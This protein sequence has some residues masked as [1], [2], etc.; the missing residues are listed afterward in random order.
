MCTMRTRMGEQG[1][2]NVLLIPVIL[3]GLLFVGAA[4]FAFWAY[5]GRQDYKNNSDAKV[6]AAVQNNT[7]A[8]Q[9]KDAKQYAEASKNPLKIYNGPDSFGSVKV[10]YPKTWS[11]YVD[12]TSNSY[13][14]DAYFHQDYVPST[15]S[16]Q[17]YNLR[18]Q[19]NSQSY[20]TQLAQYQSLIQQGK[21][22]ATPYSLPKQPSIIGT[23]LHGNVMIQNPTGVG[24][25][26][27]LPLRSTTLEIWT[28]SDSYLPDF[29]NYILPNLTFSP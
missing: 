19:V 14:L 15:Q 7:Q 10:S 17:T 16:Q 3:I 6:A 29:N 21:V 25:M 24:T 8:V 23:K 1:E 4:S 28:E 13:P 20:S 2:S 22:T 12:T 5:S 18:V 27:L 26:I 9:A 11:S